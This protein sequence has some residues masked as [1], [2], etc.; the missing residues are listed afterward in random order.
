MRT[1]KILHTARPGLWILSAFF[2]LLAVVWRFSPPISVAMD[3]G[4][5][6]L[7]HE[8]VEALSNAQWE[9]LGDGVQAMA[10]DTALGTRLTLFR[11]DPKTARLD[12]VQQSDANGENAKAVMKRTG[13]LIA[14]NGGFFGRRENGQLFPV[15]YLRDN[16]K[17]VSTPWEK[18]GGYLLLSGDGEV[19]VIPSSQPVPDDVEDV[20]QS[21]PLILE[22]GGVWAMRTNQQDQ[23]K[24]TLMCLQ[25]DGH[26][27]VM[28]VWGQGLSLYEAGWLFREK[29]RDGFF[30]CDSALA[31]DGGSSSQVAVKSRGD[32]SVAG[33]GPVQNFIV[34]LPE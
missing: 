14:F 30:G 31:L 18:T 28:V 5:P 2:V 1:K 23:E 29:G 34:V 12:L 33:L 19:S 27:V 6:P 9:A 13:A 4:T 8:A 26:V 22:P 24:R 25:P 21:R 7:A 15:G 17:S 10:V 3:N 16:R 11:I 32:L 20:L